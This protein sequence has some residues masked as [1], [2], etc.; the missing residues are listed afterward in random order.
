MSAAP[1]ADEQGMND[2][3][4]PRTRSLA[5]KAPD[6]SVLKFGLFGAGLI[7]TAILAPCGAHI[8]G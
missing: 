5:A 6:R 2:Y 4:R 3:P 7:A 1:A 8:A